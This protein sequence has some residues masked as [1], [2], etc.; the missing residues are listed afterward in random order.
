MSQLLPA[1]VWAPLIYQPDMSGQSNLGDIFVT[2]QTDRQIDSQLF[3]IHT[4]IPIIVL[5]RDRTGLTDMKTSKRILPTFDITKI[6]AK[7]YDLDNK[8][9]EGYI[10]FFEM[11]EYVFKKS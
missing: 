7:R 2:D 5:T 4:Q 11:V 10:V 8:T 6:F 9:C 1:T 3:P